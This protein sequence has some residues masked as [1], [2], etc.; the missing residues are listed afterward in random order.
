M[1]FPAGSFHKLEPRPS[2]EGLDAFVNFMGFWGPNGALPL[3]HTERSY[4]RGRDRGD[5]TLPRFL[6]VLLHRFVSLFYRAWAV[7]QPTVDFDR[8]RGPVT[9]VTLPEDAPG[10]RY[11]WY[12]ACLAGMGTDSMQDRDAIPDRAKLFYAGR[13]A[14][15]SRNA[16]GLES[17]LGGF[18]AV[19]AK[20]IPFEGFWMEIPE[21]DRC[22]LGHPDRPCRLGVDAIAGRRLWVS[23]MKCRVRLGPM[24]REKYEQLL[25]GGRSFERLVAWLRLYLGFEVGWVVQFVLKRAEIPPIQLGTN[26]KLGWTTWL[27]GRE[28]EDDAADLILQEGAA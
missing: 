2:G 26:G 21:R 28:P 4:Q 27:F 24:N 5:H 13:L 11:P 15:P 8:A 22:A 7:H 16:E 3:A 23:H 14:S 12:V 9:E 17:I 25:P 20:V 6:D 1:A 10:V 19:P 18:F